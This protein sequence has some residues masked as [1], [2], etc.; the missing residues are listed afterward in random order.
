MHSHF[1]K[2]S[3]TQRF[4]VLLWRFKLAV[5][6]LLVSAYLFSSAGYIHAKAILAQYLIEDAWQ[7]S[8]REQ[9]PVTPWSWADTWPVAEI[10]LADQ[11]M[12]VL[13]GASGRV[14]AF[15]PGHLSHTPLPGEDGNSV[16]SGHR[17]T[18]FAVLEYLQVGDRIDTRTQ[19]G[20]S[21]YRVE[22]LRIAHQ[23]Q[24]ELTYSD[25]N[26]L[27]TLI[28]CYPFHGLALDTQLR[29]VVRARKVEPI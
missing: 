27:L 23:S 8:L 24:M 13:S 25:D 16:I 10:R 3:L 7:Q 1:H 9:Q 11:V 18:H 19:Q 4:A 20:N 17:D 2:R 28:T 21:Q 14:L 5:G 29:Y 26:D 6:L 22:D 15:A 12:Y